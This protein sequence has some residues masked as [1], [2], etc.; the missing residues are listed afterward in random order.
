M[1]QYF[2][3]RI[4]KSMVDCSGKYEL[5]T[6]GSEA[7]VPSRVYRGQLKDGTQVRRKYF[8]CSSSNHET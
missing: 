4:N 7:E 1:V 2:R 3:T 8:H 6:D 5:L